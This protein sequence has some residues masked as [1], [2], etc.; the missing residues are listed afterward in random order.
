MLGAR[1]ES[2]HLALHSK[3]PAIIK[4]CRPDPDWPELGHVTFSRYSTRYREGLDLVLKDVKAD[5][6]AGTKVWC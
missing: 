1:A 6:P 4:D 3:A 2:L 5:I